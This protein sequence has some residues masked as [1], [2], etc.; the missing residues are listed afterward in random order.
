LLWEG[1]PH[2]ALGVKLKRPS[3]PLKL[4]AQQRGKSSGGNEI[5]PFQMTLLYPEEA[6]AGSK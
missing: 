2:L 6:E 1:D 5:I 4:R 3:I